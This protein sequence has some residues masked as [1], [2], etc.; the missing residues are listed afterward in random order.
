MA[1]WQEIK[2]VEGDKVSPSYPIIII[3][4]QM[5]YNKGAF[6]YRL[7]LEDY[8]FPY[9]ATEKRRRSG[10]RSC[11][12]NPKIKVWQEVWGFSRAKGKI[13]LISAPS[14]Q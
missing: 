6:T 10:N 1:V 2:F 12:Y 7:N 8:V 5:F 3:D 9:K 11:G 13:I 14:F 4:E